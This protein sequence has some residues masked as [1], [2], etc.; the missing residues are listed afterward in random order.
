MYAA[1]AAGGG[2]RLFEDELR[3]TM[4]DRVAIGHELRDALARGELSLAYQP[5]VDLPT[6][7]PSQHVEALARWNHPQRGSVPPGVFIP[8]AEAS[9]LMP[10][11]GRWVLGTAC[12]QAAAWQPGRLRRR[13]LRERL[14]AAAR[15][16]RHRP[17]VSETLRGRGSRPASSSWS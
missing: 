6:R 8:I 9:G 14:G 10:I 15:R 2:V 11:L 1:K 5:V 13:H 3:R 16:R 4:L 17:D 7:L 12:A